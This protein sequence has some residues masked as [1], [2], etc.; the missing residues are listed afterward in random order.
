MYAP[1]TV[2]LLV[3]RFGIVPT[4]LFYHSV[5]FPRRMAFNVRFL[6]T[7]EL[8]QGDQVLSL[9]SIAVLSQRSV[10]LVQLLDLLRGQKKRIT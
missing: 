3:K 1:N 9:A 4:S 7:S 10:L 5:F 6:P 2:I 8:A